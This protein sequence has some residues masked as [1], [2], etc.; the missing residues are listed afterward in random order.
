MDLSLSLDSVLPVEWIVHFLMGERKRRELPSVTQPHPLSLSD[1][2][3]GRTCTLSASPSLKLFRG[4]TPWRSHVSS[5]PCLKLGAQVVSGCSLGKHI[6]LRDRKTIFTIL[7][8]S[9]FW[10]LFWSPS[11]WSLF[12][13]IDSHWAGKKRDAI[14]C[15]LL[16]LQQ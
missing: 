5:Q 6:W 16:R 15:F 4:S 3:A 8:L 10:V 13:L 14:Y 7:S 1:S 11:V 12:F 9:L 2:P